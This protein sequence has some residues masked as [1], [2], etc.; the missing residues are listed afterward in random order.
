MYTLSE[1]GTVETVNSVVFDSGLLSFSKLVDDHCISPD[2][3]NVLADPE[4]EEMVPTY[5][6]QFIAPWNMVCHIVTSIER[7]I[8]RY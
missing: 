8:Y 5:G 4:D 3:L 7:H 6:V 2:A 1:E